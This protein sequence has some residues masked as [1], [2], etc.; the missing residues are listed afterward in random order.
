MQKKN[1]ARFSDFTNTHELLVPK[2]LCLGD[3]NC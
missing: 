2:K 3:S 1:R